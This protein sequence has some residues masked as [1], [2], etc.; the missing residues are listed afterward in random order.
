M[1]SGSTRVDRLIVAVTLTA[2]ALTSCG[3][4]A[5]PVPV[6]LLSQVQGVKNG[7]IVPGLL[8]ALRSQ[9]KLDGVTGID[10][11]KVFAA[12]DKQ[13]GRMVADSEAELAKAPDQVGTAPDPIF[14]GGR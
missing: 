9:F 13:Y 7:D 10:P 8:G 14:K 2:T 4:Q 5:A 3:Q 1:R 12:V 6:S 11:A